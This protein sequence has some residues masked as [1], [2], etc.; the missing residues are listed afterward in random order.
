MSAPRP[1]ASPGRTLAGR[2]RLERRIGLGGMGEVWAAEQLALA[3]PVAVKLLGSEAARQPEAMARFEIEARALARVDDEHVLRILDFGHDAELGFFLVTD[4]LEGELLSALLSRQARL[5]Q[6]RAVSIA[7]GILDGLLAAHRAGVVHRDLKP[8]NV[9]LVDRG[10]R[11]VPKLLDFGI[12]KLL[13]APSLDLTESGVSLGTP[14]YLAPEQ[15]LGRAVD[16]RAD[17]YAVGVLLF[18]ML[19]GRLPFEAPSVTALAVQHATA[20]PPPLPEDAGPPALAAVVARALE[21]DPERRYADAAALRWALLEAVA[22]PSAGPA[23]LASGPQPALSTTGPTLL[24]PPAAPAA[25]LRVAVVGPGAPARAIAAALAGAE[26]ALR[27]FGGRLVR[28]APDGLHAILP[29]AEEALPCAA[30]IVDRVAEAP[31][32]RGV[33][34]RVAVTAATPS[35]AG[36]SLP[37][38][39]LAR[40]DAIVA[41]GAPGEVLFAEELVPPP[42]LAAAAHPGE[43]PGTRR[44]VQRLVP[45]LAAARRDLPFGGIGLGRLDSLWSR[46]VARGAER[47]RTVAFGGFRG[48]GE[49]FG[50]TLRTLLVHALARPRLALGIAAS[51]L[52]CAAVATFALWPPR[53]EA[54]IERA[55]ARGRAVEAR[56]IAEGLVAERPADA[57]ARLL[58]ARAH[59]AS[60]ESGRALV[61]LRR[62]HEL[63]PSVASSPAFGAVLARCLDQPD[64]GAAIAL[65]LLVGEGLEPALAAALSDPAHHARWNAARAL[66]ALGLGARVDELELWARDLRGAPGCDQRSAALKRLAR[67]EDPRALEAL[68]DARLEL[69]AAEQ[70]ALSCQELP[71]EIDRALLRREGTAKKP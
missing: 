42:P 60:G 18:R 32:A 24:P 5:G 17:L 6:E 57:A 15:A 43:D 13:D 2:Y 34:V 8:G 25:G 70:G 30:T 71:Q 7:A 40:L 47:A 27:A 59:V 50:R 33:E 1:A 10:G 12:A 11:E 38:D 36:L 68:V 55:L 4:R 19:V 26:E 23:F 44:P 51:V 65:A 52:A 21:K 3:R 22:S 16:H 39:A 54:A 41:L 66:Q 37:G 67:S 9:M 61:E 45:P 58:L 64:A 48:G 63:A 49:L 28:F 69:A 20:T 14:Q 29:A 56:S 35:G 62:A 46:K 31:A 53:P